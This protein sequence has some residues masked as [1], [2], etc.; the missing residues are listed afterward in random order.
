MKVYQL[1]ALALGMALLTLFGACTGGKAGGAIASDDT[2]LC[3][4]RNINRMRSVSYTDSDRT[5]Y[6]V[7]SIMYV[8]NRFTAVWPVTLNGKPCTALQRAL[9]DELVY[10]IYDAPD[11]QYPHFGDLDSLIDYRLS[12]QIPAQGVTALDKPAS[13]TVKSL[14]SSISVYLQS[15]DQRMATVRV[16]KYEYA[17]GAH[18]AYWKE[19]FT[20]D[21][22]ND[23]VLQ[24]SDVVADTTLLKRLTL[25]AFKD[26]PNIDDKN[27]WLPK[28]GLPPLPDGFYLDRYNQGLHTIYQAYQIGSYAQGIID[29]TIALFPLDDEQ[30]KQLLT[31]RARQLLGFDK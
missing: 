11:A 25:Q 14:S 9:L 24:F 15:L 28:D 12:Y 10:N 19:Y 22:A 8:N 6:P 5:G 3:Q 2:T 29:A 17:G 13:D 30:L 23:R 26:D 7:D 20:Y 4:F 21:I 18:G 27:L 1:P 31:P 16:E